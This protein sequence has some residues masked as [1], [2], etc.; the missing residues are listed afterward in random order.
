[1]AARQVLEVQT[2][3]LGP[4]T[5]T[6]PHVD[7]LAVGGSGFLQT[8]PEYAMKRLL[9]AGAPSIYQLGPVFRAG[10][11]GRL[12]SQEF[13]MLEWYRLGFNDDTLMAEVAELVDT[14]LGPADYRKL[15]YAQLLSQSPEP[16]GAA[17]DLRIA[18]AIEQLGPARIF[19]V[20]YPARHAALARL[21]ADDA[22]VAARFELVVN[23]VEL[24]NGYFEL[25]DAVQ[26]RE[27]F[28]SDNAQRISLGKP[29][30]ALD[31][32]FLAAMEAG[33]PEC[34]GVALGVDRLIMLAVG[35]DR[36]EQVLTFMH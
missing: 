31:E 3:V 32:A 14:I 15:S 35:A 26:L 27:R 19:I 21:R 12:H 29:Q 16:A 9:A 5:V 4:A 18:A 7:A 34:A 10:E 8:S 6:D 13:T 2:P 36:L 22:A 25:G 33:L 20:D 30:I 24:A 23:G 17:E 28:E 1:M 11:A